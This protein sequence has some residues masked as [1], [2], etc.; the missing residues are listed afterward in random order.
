MTVN[1]TMRGLRKDQK[2]F[3]SDEYVTHTVHNQHSDLPTNVEHGGSVR[4]PQ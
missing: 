1:G 4:L 3:L 2:I